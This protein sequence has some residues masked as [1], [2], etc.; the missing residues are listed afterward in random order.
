MRRLLAHSGHL[1]VT[2]PRREDRMRVFSVFQRARVLWVLAMVA[3]LASCGSPDSMPGS[4]SR[5]SCSSLGW[6]CGTD[7]FGRLCGTCSAGSSC[8]FGTCGSTTCMP[9]CGARTCGLDSRCGTSCGTCSGSQTCSASGTCVTAMPTCSITV[10][11]PCVVGGS[12]CC[13]PVFDGTQTLCSTT[14]TG[15]SFCAPRCA[16]D[17]IC[18]SL[19]RTS[20]TWFCGTRGDG[21]RVCFLR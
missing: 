10:F 8:N 15:I 13:A 20:G 19:T 11:M 14:T 21:I 12:Q 4:D 2:G 6:S 3:V 18:D 9:V 7:D 5:R 17:A 16:S 1:R